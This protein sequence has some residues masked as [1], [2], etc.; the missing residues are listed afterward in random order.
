MIRVATNTDM[1]SAVATLA[2][3][4]EH[5]PLVSYFVRADTK[6]SAALINFFTL[7]MAEQLAEG[8]FVEIAEE[9]KAVAM[10]V[11]PGYHTASE[12]LSA[13]L[14]LAPRF[15]RISGWARLLRGLAIGRL[16]DQIHP[17]TPCWYLQFLGC[18][19]A[20]QGRGLGSSLLRHRLAAIDAEAAD[21]F[22]ETAQPNNLPLYLRHGF[23]VAPEV[24][25]GREGPAVWPMLRTAK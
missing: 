3:A 20:A 10:W 5:D 2:A 11:A 7:M 16:L 18:H 25:P 19:P 13:Q 23:A 22:L 17:K 4:F 15:L 21:A 14:R 24:R 8:V 1:P 9:G 6:R 12:G